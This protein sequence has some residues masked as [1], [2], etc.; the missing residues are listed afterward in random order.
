MVPDLHCRKMPQKKQPLSLEALGLQAGG[1]FVSSIGRMIISSK[2]DAIALNRAGA[3]ENMFSYLTEFLYT[4]VPWN[5]FDQMATHVLT[6]ISNLIKETKNN[7]NQDQ[8]M[9]VF[10]NKM[11][12]VVS[13]TEVAINPHLRCIDI[14]VWPKIMRHVLYQRL[15][16]MTGLEELNLGSGSGG[17]KTSDIEKSI[18]QGVSAMQNLT[19]L[20]LCFDCTDHII[21]IVGQ[22][23][24]KLQNLDVT[25]SRSVT[26]RS[27][28]PLLNCPQLRQLLLY[29]TSVSIEGYT[30]LLLGLRQL[31]DLGRCDELG[32]IL[33][34]LK[35]RN[36]VSEPLGLEVF[37]SRDVTTTHLNLLVEMCP[38]V[39]H[40]SI[41]HDERV[42]DLTVLIYLNNL[43]ELK[44]LACDFYTDQV[45][46]MLEVR[47]EKLTWLHLEHVEEI[48]LNALV[49]ISQFCPHLKKLVL[50][51]CDFLEHT[52]LSLKKLKVVPFQYLEQIICVV[53]C[54]LVHLEF[55]LSH[56]INIKCIQL[57]SSTG[58][59]DET[60]AKVLAVNPMRKLEELKILFS[61]NLSMQT[62]QFLMTR[63]DNLRVLTELES[64]QGITAEELETFRKYLILNNIDLDIRSKFSY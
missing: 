46:Q 31:K 57:G 50:Y 51:N 34:N 29:R 60:M 47:G 26:D 3:M 27:V 61:D 62:V 10:L 40:V 59:G 24:C 41:F 39:R 45:K 52:S 28:G 14:S 30:E 4:H 54:A 25:S 33:E 37:Q 15:Y 19:S 16:R 6:S 42:S 18:I 20:C 55:L 1:E 5:L 17:W 9:S 35:E 63:C 53:D 11:K 56:C 22:T 44:L 8:P 2:T 64:W 12:V 23:C 32:I 36:S 49:Y 48:D 21:S 38:N 58:I 13:L 43:S 7:Y